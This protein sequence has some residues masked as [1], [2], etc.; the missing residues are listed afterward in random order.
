MEEWRIYL[1]PLGFLSA[2]LFGV[3]F[4][5]QWIQSE[6]IGKSV[7]N[8]TFWQIS[9][10]GNLILLFHSFIQIQYHVC[11]VQGLNAVISW[12]NIN[13]LQSDHPVSFKKVIERLVM[14]PFIISLLFF[15]QD[16]YLGN[17]SFN[18]F[19]TPGTPWN[20]LGASDVYPLWHAIGFLGVILF[21]SRFW[22]Q[23]WEAEKTFSSQLLPSFWWI[24]LAGACLTLTYSLRIHDLVNAVGPILGLVPYIR[25]LMLIK[26]GTQTSL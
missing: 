22:I 25:N 18:W 3:R 17:E 15:L 10:L 26:R 7:V 14:T 5:I 6:I 23:W 21:S 19:R 12:R 8:K 1:Y 24:S 4:I 9:L 16:Y 11:L 13:L 20:P 2:I